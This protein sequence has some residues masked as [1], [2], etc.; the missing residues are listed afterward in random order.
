MKKEWRC[1]RCSKLLGV[2]SDGRIHLRFARG[3]EYLVGF[4]ATSVC[5]GCRTLNE[6]RE[7]TPETSPPVAHAAPE[8][9]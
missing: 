5:R 1:S 6:L 3:H 7:Q 2:L 8:Q 9:G 4:P